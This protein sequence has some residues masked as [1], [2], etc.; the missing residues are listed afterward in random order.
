MDWNLFKLIILG[1]V[2][3]TIFYVLFKTPA[4]KNETLNR[5]LG[6]KDK[7]DIQTHDRPFVKEFEKL[8]NEC[9]VTNQD[10]NYSSCKGYVC[11]EANCVQSA[12]SVFLHTT[13]SDYNICHSK[14]DY[15]KN[16][17]ASEY[18]RAVGFQNFNDE[19]KNIP[20]N[21]M[22]IVEMEGRYTTLYGFG[23]TY[24]PHHYFSME[25]RKN[26]FYLYSSWFQKFTLE[27]FLDIPR[28]N[29]FSSALN[30][31]KKNYIKKLRN[32]CGLQKILTFQENDLVN[33]LKAFFYIFD[34]YNSMNEN[35]LDFKFKCQQ[36]NKKF[37]LLNE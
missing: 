18:Q 4:T 10:N 21:S 6:N 3:S 30:D 25:I 33:C 32:Q 12:E 24:V 35:T 19:I 16:I 23:I 2:L 5:T 31:P 28:K 15:W 36:L 27:W 7:N 17:F 1:T 13:G 14:E 37:I 34:D 26:G 11:C 22:C 29:E 9:I 20:V 8:M